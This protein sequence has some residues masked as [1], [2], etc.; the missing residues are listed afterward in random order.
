ML[1]SFILKNIKSKEEGEEEEEVVSY[2]Y[3]LDGSYPNP[4][5][6]ETVGVFHWAITITI[7]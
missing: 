7:V 5:F 6:V 3:A 1:E 4:G 2:L